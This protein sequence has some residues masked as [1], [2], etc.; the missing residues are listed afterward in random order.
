MGFVLVILPL[1]VA[2]VHATYSVDRLVAQGQRA[3]FATVRA[4]QNSQVLVESITAMER[5]A[6]QYKV[7]DLAI[8]NNSVLTLSSDAAAVGFQGVEITAQNLNI[9]AGSSFSGSGQ[10]YGPGTGPGAGSSVQASLPML[11]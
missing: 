8:T 6:R 7:H 5:N 1:M 3:L 4:T 2:L 11:R 10:G 9:E